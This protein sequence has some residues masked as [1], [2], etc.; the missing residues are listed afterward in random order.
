[1][2]NASG[3]GKSAV[4]PSEIDRWNWGAFMLNW[5][6][7]IGNQVYIALLMFIPFVNLVMVFVLG[8]KGSTWAWQNKRWESIEHFKRVQRLWAIGGVVTLVLM[9][10]LGAGMYFAASYMLKNSDAY[11]FGVA[12]LQASARAMALLGPPL[13]TGMPK[14]SVQTSGPT[15]EAKLSIPVEGQKAKGVVYLDAAKDM[16]QWKANRIVLEIDG[17]QERIDL[18]RTPED[19][20]TEGMRV[21]QQ[22]DYAKAAGLF[23]IAAEAGNADAQSQLAL[24]YANGQGVTQNYKQ[25]TAWWEKA[26]AQ[27][28]ALAQNNLGVLYNEGDGVSQDPKQAASWFE[29][30][31]AQ[32]Y[33]PAQ[34]AL[35]FLYDTGRGVE[36]DF[37]KAA[38]L[39]RIAAEAGDADAQSQLA[40][41]YTNGQGV[42]QDYK[43]GTVWY[44]KAAAQG[45]ALAQ[46]NLGLLYAEG[47]GTAQDYAEAYKWWVL[48]KDSDEDAKSNLGTIEAKMTPDQI[49]D[50]QRRVDAWRNAHR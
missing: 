29:K 40:F 18:N 49:A 23:R 39:F 1:M 25:A 27:G 19:D 7:G 21:Y 50:G 22:G 15:G 8:A 3:Q 45:D 33:P 43:Q 13:K 17:N 46:Y 48:A 31:A 35:G 28:D 6:W 5:I 11:R 38:G 16:G 24:V 2:E 12:K 32:G 37:A 36:Q 20:F 30:A 4:V 44:E 42:T 10:V 47:Q 41:M 14:G 9:V 34:T 26:A